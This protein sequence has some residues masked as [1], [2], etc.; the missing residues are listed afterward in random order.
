MMTN[1]YWLCIFF[2]LSC[3]NWCFVDLLNLGHT[4]TDSLNGCLTDNLLSI[5]SCLLD[6]RPYSLHFRLGYA[7]SVDV[8]SV[9]WK[10]LSMFKTLNGRPT[11]E[12]SVERPVDVLCDTRP[13]R[14][15]FVSVTCPWCRKISTVNGIIHPLE[16]WQINSSTD[17][18]RT[19]NG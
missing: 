13:F 7:L 10:I 8:R 15:R 12:L 19:F 16:V 4:L 1:I 11:D 6:V 17:Y 5:C 2:F 9:R 3:L 18:Y 14:F